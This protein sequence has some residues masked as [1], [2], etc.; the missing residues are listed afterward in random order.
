MSSVSSQSVL[1][2]VILIL[3]W[4]IS[5]QWINA[6]KLILLMSIINT[7]KSIILSFFGFHEFP[8][9]DVGHSPGSHTSWIAVKMPTI[10]VLIVGHTLANTNIEGNVSM[11]VINWKCCCSVCIQISCYLLYMRESKERQKQCVVHHK[12]CGLH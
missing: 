11:Q 6:R 2:L 9:S 7:H 3:L 8:F 12:T 1:L 5:L 10:I 4:L